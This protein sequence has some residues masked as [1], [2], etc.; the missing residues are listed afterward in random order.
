M[1]ACAG[2]GRQESMAD[3]IERLIQI[4]AAP[5]QKEAF[6]AWL[7]MESALDLLRDNCR[8]DELVLYCSW[9]TFIHGILVPTSSVN[10]PNT[11]D[12]MSWNCNATSSWG[13]T[14]TFSEP[15]SAFLSPPL[16]NTGSKTLEGGEQLVFDRSFEG[17]TGKKGYC[18]ILQK[19][20]HTF[21]L[22]LMEERSAYCRLDKHGDIEEVIRIVEIEEKRGGS[23]ATV[24]TFNRALLDEYLVL[25]DSVLVL[26]FDFVRYRP[27][28]FSGWRDAHDVRYSGD[29]E[30]FIACTSR[31]GTRVTYAASTSWVRLAQGNRLSNA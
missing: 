12:L 23:G 14:V 30:I 16:S 3:V 9:S 6:D 31:P 2:K 22:H 20:I 13:I 18:E 11:D 15:R 26:T 10:P 27:G 25:T 1:P 24:I 21:D 7:E 5:S 29:G 8:Q 4:S 28:Q 19:L 17:R